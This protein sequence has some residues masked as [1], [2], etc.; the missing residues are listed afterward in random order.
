[1]LSAPTIADEAVEVNA[2]QEAFIASAE[3]GKAQFETICAHCHNTTY[4]ESR[5]GAPGLMGVLERHSEVWLNQW[6][7]SPE[8]FAQIDVA[9]RDLIDGNTFG[10]AMPTLPAMQDEKSRLDIIEYLKT[11]KE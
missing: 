8:D 4:E 9:A 6:L 11:L 7:K 2:E 3:R 10:L 1:M 5:I